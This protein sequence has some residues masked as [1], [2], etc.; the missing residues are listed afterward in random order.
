MAKKRAESGGGEP[1]PRNEPTSLRLPPETI[2][3]INLIAKWKNLP[4]HL[5]IEPMIRSP[6]A[7]DW[8]EFKRWAQETD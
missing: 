4:A 6:L 5:Y 3:R 8:A 2:R 1:S 7:K